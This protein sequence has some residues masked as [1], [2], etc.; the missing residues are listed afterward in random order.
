MIAGMTVLPARLTRLAP[1]GTRTLAALPTCVKRAPLTMN[2]AFSSGA[3]PSPVMMRAASNSVTAD[4]GVCAGAVADHAA[5]I[6]ATDG[7]NHDSLRMTNTPCVRNCIRE[8]RY[9]RGRM[10]WRRAEYVKNGRLR[11]ALL[12]A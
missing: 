12:T 3:R 6:T 7:I 2:E 1:A 10:S 9:T 4:A 11:A 8:Q 5:A